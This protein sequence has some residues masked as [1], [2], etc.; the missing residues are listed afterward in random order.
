[1]QHLIKG[2]AEAWTTMAIFIITSANMRHQVSRSAAV[3]SPSPRTGQTARHWAALRAAAHLL[4]ALCTQLCQPETCQRCHL[5]LT[6]G[7]LAMWMTAVLS[8]P[9]SGAS[10]DT[11]ITALLTLAAKL[12]RG[13]C[14]PLLGH[15]G[16]GTQGL[17]LHGICVTTTWQNESLELSELCSVHLG[18]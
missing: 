6:N 5:L 8:E 10:Q 13:R 3:E 17:A 11:G 15:S 18:I 7:E 9:S 2:Q 4:P 14:I 1:M 16:K 12:G